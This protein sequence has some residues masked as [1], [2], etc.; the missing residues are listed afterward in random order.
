MAERSWQ[1]PAVFNVM[2]TLAVLGAAVG[3]AWMAWLYYEYSPWTRDGRVRVYTVPVAPEV[4]GRV[5]SLL[6][7]DDQFVHKGDLLFQID[8]RTFQNDVTQ[9]KG[10]LEAAKAR[11]SY[12]AAVAKRR[13]VQ[14]N[15]S[16]SDEDKQNTAGVADAAEATVFEATGQLDQANL[17]VERTA[18]H[19]P[20]NGW[21][22]NLLLQQGG[23]ATTGQPALTL[24][25]ADSFWV[26]GY[27]A[28]TQTAR[29]RDG[30]PAHVVLMGYPSTDVRGH[31]VGIG[32]GISV[33]DA[34]PSTQGLPQVNPVFTWVR[35]AQRIPVRV[36]LDD[37]P[38]PVM[39]SAGMTATVTIVGSETFADAPSH[40]KAVRTG[41]NAAWACEQ[42][43]PAQR[44]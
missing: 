4:S 9:A 31:V 26:D 12:L 41:A 39:L 43:E 23:F 6:V 42:T 18:L 32:R 7:K 15:L 28:E 21:V 19:S 40:A 16:A 24:V 20:V 5:V 1:P 8:P 10:R 35:L 17:D 2:A 44:K 30:A 14:T 25:D 3:L 38:C 11:A 22:T 36:A 33:S 29:I 27:F 34:T 13:A 37:V